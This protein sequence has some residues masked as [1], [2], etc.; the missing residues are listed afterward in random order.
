MKLPGTRFIRYL[1][2]CSV[3]CVFVI[4]MTWSAISAHDQAL[5]RHS[6][7]LN[8]CLAQTSAP[9]VTQGSPCSDDAQL[10]ALAKQ[11]ND[12]DEKSSQWLGISSILMVILLAL[13]TARIAVFLVNAFS[14]RD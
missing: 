5:A 3:L 2:V 1:S 4:G 8:A 7:A 10:L 13:V 6:A 11:V 12:A 14:R 9:T